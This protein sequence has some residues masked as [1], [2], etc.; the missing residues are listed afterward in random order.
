VPATSPT[1]LKGRWTGADGRYATLRF[2]RNCSGRGPSCSTIPGDG[3]EGEGGF[4]AG[5]NIAAAFVEFAFCS[6]AGAAGL[7]FEG[8]TKCGGR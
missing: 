4:V 5:L 3:G 1:D 6:G 2:G 7:G 8:R